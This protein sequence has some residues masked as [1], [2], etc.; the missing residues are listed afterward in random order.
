MSVGS[1]LGNMAPFENSMLKNKKK[2]LLTPSYKKYHQKASKA[3]SDVSYN[4]FN[5]RKSLLLYSETL[6]F[7]MRQ[8][9]T[10]DSNI[11]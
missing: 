9:S 3:H 10:K 8:V 5:K 7:T 11:T 2:F 6:H 4:G 1:H